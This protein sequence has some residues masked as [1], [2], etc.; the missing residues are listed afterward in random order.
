[1]LYTSEFICRAISGQIRQSTVHWKQQ[2]SSA[3]PE[4]KRRRKV[5]SRAQ[6]EGAASNGQIKSFDQVVSVPQPRGRHEVK[7]LERSTEAEQQSQLLVIVI[8]FTFTTNVPQENTT[9]PFSLRGLVVNQMQ[10]LKQLML[11]VSIHLSNKCLTGKYH[12]DHFSMWDLVLDKMQRLKQ[13]SFVPIHPYKKYF[14]EN[15][16]YHFSMRELVLNLMRE[17]RSRLR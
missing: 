5:G 1:M 4:R 2:T 10:R 8:P 17:G 6:V 7:W 3:E 13:M 12:C 11:N 15:I 14:T 9:Y 16:T